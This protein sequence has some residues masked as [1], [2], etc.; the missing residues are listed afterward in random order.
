MSQVKKPSSAPPDLEVEDDGPRSAVQ[1]KAKPWLDRKLESLALD[2][3]EGL[4]TP[5]EMAQ[6]MVEACDRWAAPYLTSDARAQV[7]AWME[8]LASTELAVD[9]AWEES[10]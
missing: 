2:C 1:L 3:E 8:D 5:E 9:K 7:K 6:Q 10:E 4:I